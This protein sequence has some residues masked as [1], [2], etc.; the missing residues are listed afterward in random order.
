MS[1]RNPYHSSWKEDRYP[2]SPHLGNVDC[3]ATGANIVV[4]ERGNGIAIGMKIVF[5]GGVAAS[6]DYSSLRIVS[7]T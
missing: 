6:L 7:T 2:I 3:L 1:F 5:G 4:R